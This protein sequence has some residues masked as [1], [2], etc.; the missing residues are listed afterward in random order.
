MKFLPA[1]GVTRATAHEPW[2]VC[3]ENWI[4]AEALPLT[5]CVVLPKSP[6]LSV[7]HFLHVQSVTP[8][9]TSQYTVRNG[10]MERKH[11]G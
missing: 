9:I 8:N 1:L 10:V 5:S 7:P 3:Q 6:N 4:Q 11:F 2:M